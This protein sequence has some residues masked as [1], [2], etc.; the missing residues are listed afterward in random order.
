MDSILTPPMTLGAPG[1]PISSSCARNPDEYLPHTFIVTYTSMYHSTQQ[2]SW[3]KRLSFRAVDLEVS[4]IANGGCTG[5]YDHFLEP[6]GGLATQTH[7]LVP[8]IL[9]STCHI[10]SYS[11]IPLCGK[12]KS[13]FLAQEAEF[14]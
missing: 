7:P 8:G 14:G 5:K 12:Y 10:H 13:G 11:H 1:Y 2:A 9:M 3:H 6:L 4:K